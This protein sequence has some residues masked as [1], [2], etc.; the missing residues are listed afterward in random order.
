MSVPA[1][2][3]LVV[4]AATAKNAPSSGA[5]PDAAVL[6]VAFHREVV[7]LENGTGQ[8]A[9]DAPGGTPVRPPFEGDVW[10]GEIARQLPG[11]PPR[12]RAHAV[13]FAVGFE[14]ARLVR[15]RADANLNGDLSD[16]ADARL[17]LYPGDPPGRSFLVPLRWQSTQGS[18]DRPVERLV[19][20]VV[21]PVGPAR[22]YFTQDVYGMLGSVDLGG[23]PKLALLYDANYD[24]VYTKGSGD[25]WF[26]DQDGDRHFGIDV[27]GPDFGS[28]SVP[29]VL[30]RQE[31]VVDDV[32]PSGARV[33]LRRLGAAV[34][35]PSVEVGAAVPDFAFVDTEG[36]AVLLSARRGDPVVVYFWAS[37][38]VACREAAGGLRALYEHYGPDGVQFLGVS[39]D[40]DRAAMERFR[41]E[42]EL[43]WPNAFSGG[44]PSEDPVGRI[45]HE[46]RA[47]VFYVVD[48]DGRLA[49]KTSDLSELNERLA[50]MTAGAR[51]T[52]PRPRPGA[53]SSPTHP[54]G[55]ASRGKRGR[56][57]AAA[58]TV[59]WIRAR[60]R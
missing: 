19:R 49:V 3:L 11:D 40:T 41:R 57:R 34:P 38:S 24:G 42:N 8:L 56:R 59:G 32:D 43:S 31:F 28:F 5:P 14:G 37:S 21:E 46:E 25:G 60:V 17:S 1:F 16:D 39:Y 58:R 22:R 52:P 12:S 26:V 29:F 20:V 4:A 23:G 47:G 27:M 54:A 13:S 2:A 33:S 55:T 45:F 15:A 51:P 53:P 6:E 48:P 7:N 9:R 44:I 50:A 35:A 36:R 30:G 10:Y 18:A